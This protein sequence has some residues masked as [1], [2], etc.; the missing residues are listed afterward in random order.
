[1]LERVDNWLHNSIPP[2][3]QKPDSSM[4]CAATEH[5]LQYHG[6]QLRLLAQHK[7]TDRHT[8]SSRQ[9]AT[10]VATIIGSW[11]DLN[12]CGSPWRLDA[13]KVHKSTSMHTTL[14]SVLP[15]LE[16]LQARVVNTRPVMQ[17]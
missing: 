4:Q 9:R 2:S 14:Q 16:Q 11:H 8:D 5:K 1:M 13:A 15:L 10:A 12:I 17:K 3:L 7:A 6:V